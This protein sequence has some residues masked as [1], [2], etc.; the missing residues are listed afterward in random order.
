MI[1]EWSRVI[2]VRAETNSN[3]VCSSLL[4]SIFFLLVST[5]WYLVKRKASLFFLFFFVNACSAKLFNASRSKETLVIVLLHKNEFQNQICRKFSWTREQPY[6]GQ[7]WR[8]WSAI[9]YIRKKVSLSLFLRR[10]F[11]VWLI[12]RVNESCQD[13]CWRPGPKQY[14]K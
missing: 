2:V 1:S 7:F 11:A 6:I 4:V 14:A 3:Y 10:W 5:M 8:S 12:T 13:P 9:P